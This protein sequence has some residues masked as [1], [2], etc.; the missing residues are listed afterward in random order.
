MKKF[1][2]LRSTNR[3]VVLEINSAPAIL[4]NRK[5]YN[6]CFN[7]NEAWHYDNDKIWAFG[8]DT[9]RPLFNK[10]KDVSV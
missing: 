5:L 1:R 4:K 10:G 7:I 8:R 2:R 9:F 6:I 3:H